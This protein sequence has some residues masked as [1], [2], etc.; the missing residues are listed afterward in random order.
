[1]IET[2]DDNVF[3]DLLR[4]LGKGDFSRLERWFTGP[5]TPKIVEWYRQ[6]RFRDN[7]SALAEALTCAC[8]L[9]ANPAA[10]YLLTEGIDPSGGSGTGLNAL[11][12]AANRGQL[13]TIRLLIRHGAPLEVQSM[14]GSAALGT[15]V[16]S[17]IHESRPTHP[18]IIEELLHAGASLTSVEYPTGH[19]KVDEILGREIRRTKEPRDG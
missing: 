12:W 11:H 5:G 19:P 3:R 6:G 7:P 2:N 17:A 18:K 1:M 8:F 13:E 14:Y 15:A 9:G 4:G 16:W 10:E